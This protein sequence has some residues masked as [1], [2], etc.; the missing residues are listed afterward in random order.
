MIGEIEAYEL[1]DPG[2]NFRDYIV[3]RRKPAIAAHSLSSI[4]TTIAVLLYSL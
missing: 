2:E 3:F 4:A 1:V